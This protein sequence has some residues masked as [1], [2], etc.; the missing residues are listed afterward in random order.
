MKTLRQRME[1]YIEPA[2]W[3]SF[4]VGF[5]VMPLTWLTM[6][7][8]WKEIFYVETSRS[9]D[10]IN[11]AIAFVG[12]F[13]GIGCGIISGVVTNVMFAIVSKDRPK[14]TYDKDDT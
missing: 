3:V 6:C 13:V 1:E 9:L 8:F 7:Y 10:N 11:T 12:I 5:I 4:A 14:D 2:V